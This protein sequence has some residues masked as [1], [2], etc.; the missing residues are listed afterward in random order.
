MV[1]MGHMQLEFQGNSNL[2]EQVQKCYRIWATGNP[3]NDTG[4][5]WN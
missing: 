4:S 5:L 3:H 1:K 2:L